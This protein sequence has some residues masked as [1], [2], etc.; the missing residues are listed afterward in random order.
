MNK[1]LRIIVITIIIGGFLAGFY[2]LFM[3]PIGFVTQEAVV[4]SYINNL[5]EENCETHFV[6]EMQD[7]CSQFVT[8]LDGE[9]F[10]VIEIVESSNTV[11]VTLKINEI[12]ETFTFFVVT[13]EPGGLRGILTSN[14][15]KI[16]HIE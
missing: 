15:Y 10:E 4:S 13:E 3:R 1:L 7:V 6:I 11:D 5:D 16:D 14:Y 12:E 9:E 2:F 8:L